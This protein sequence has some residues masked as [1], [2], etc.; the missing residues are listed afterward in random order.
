MAA[1][2]EFSNRNSSLMITEVRIL[3]IRSIKTSLK[4]L[5][6][7]S[8]YIVTLNFHLGDN[9]GTPSVTDIEKKKTPRELAWQ[10]DTEKI[11]KKSSST[12]RT[13]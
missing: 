11:A 10:N 4:G 1:L 5:P 2:S 13:A 7:L 6:S 9:T 3:I 8:G 12:Q